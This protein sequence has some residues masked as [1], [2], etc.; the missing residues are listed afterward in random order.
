MSV[1]KLLSL[2]SF[3]LLYSCSINSDIKPEDTFVKFYGGDGN[4]EL[5]DMIFQ[6][7]NQSGIVLFGTRNG[8]VIEDEVTY[9]ESNFYVITVD[10]DGTV[11]NEVM[12][13]VDDGAGTIYHLNDI[14]GRI[15]ATS[16]G[17]YL[18]VGT[19]KE[20]PVNSLL[21]DYIVWAR[22]D[23]SLSLV[24]SWNFIG[25]DFNNYSGTDI[26]EMADGGVLVSGYTDING[27]NDFYYQK[28]GGTEPEW[29][30]IENR[31]N[32]DDKLIRA[33][34]T[35]N[36][37]YAL[38]GETEAISGDGETGINVERTV[39]SPEGIIQN[40][41]IYGISEDGGVRN[42]SPNDIVERPG[43]FAI[44]GT[45]TLN[46]L[47]FEPFVMLVDL[48]GAKTGEI[49]YQNE[50]SGNPII[51]SSGYGLGLVQLLNND[52]FVLGSI[53]D[54]Q[55]GNEN[56][57]GEGFVFKTD[58]DGAL[59]G[60][61]SSYGLVNGDDEFVR[62]LTSNDGTVYIGGTYDFGGGLAQMVLLKV[63]SQGILKK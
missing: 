20:V 12:L 46:N 39:I 9:L 55:V 23:A 45:S 16:D 62:G 57:G 43:G 22:L 30:R 35:E 42:D 4:F 7:A 10:L 49:L 13:E 1:R 53:T 24:G 32:S 47:D 58:Q 34:P 61:I 25:N 17:G 63:N 28:I 26:T 50:F 59:Q 37:N 56:R 38:F 27:S 44:V 33:L 52:Y 8:E 6:D 3:S 5:V 60:E 40:S 51:N 21:L 29:T 41:L 15:S 31:S 19:I 18:I 54:L 48:T 11:Q 14:A 36:G 2:L